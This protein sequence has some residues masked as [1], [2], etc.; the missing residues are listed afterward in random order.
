MQLFQPECQYFGYDK[1]IFLEEPA[2]VLD[3]FIKTTYCSIFV[4]EGYIAVIEHNNVEHQHQKGVLDIS[5]HLE[6]PII[7]WKNVQKQV[8]LG[9]SIVS[10]VLCHHS[11][12]SK[13]VAGRVLVS[14]SYDLIL[15]LH[16]YN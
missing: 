11:C 12:L 4:E 7:L 3:N 9:H 1:S 14:S 10:L 5:E 15:S 2:I 6:E 8:S 13:R 16:S